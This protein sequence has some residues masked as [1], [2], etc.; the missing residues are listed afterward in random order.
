VTASMLTG[1]SPLTQ[2]GLAVIAGGGVAGVVQGATVLA[3]TVSTT[4]SAGLAN[5]LI[6]TAELGFAGFFAFISLALPVVAVVLVLGLL[7]FMVIKIRRRF[8]VGQGK[9]IC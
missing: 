4:A 9:A 3:R 2:W 5:P 6:S 1:M 8:F 7:I